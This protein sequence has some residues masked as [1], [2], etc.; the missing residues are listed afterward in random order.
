MMMMNL[1]KVMMII[2]VHAHPD[3]F[4]TTSTQIPRHDSS[5]KV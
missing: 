5:P 1:L 4:H 3:D 2:I